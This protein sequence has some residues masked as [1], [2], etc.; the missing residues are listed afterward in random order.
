MSSR[1]SSPACGILSDG[2]PQPPRSFKRQQTLD[3][4]Y[5]ATKIR[6]AIRGKTKGE[7]WATFDMQQ[8][9]DI[10]QQARLNLKKYRNAHANM[11]TIEFYFPEKYDEDEEV[12]WLKRTFGEDLKPAVRG[13][14][15]AAAAYDDQVDDEEEMPKVKTEMEHEFE[16]PAAVKG[17]DAVT[18]GKEKI[19]VS[20][21]V[22]SAHDDPVVKV[23]CRGFVLGDGGAKVGSKKA[24]GMKKGGTA[25]MAKVGPQGVRKGRGIR[26]SWKWVGG[27]MV[28][29]PPFDAVN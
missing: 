19:A 11:R 15:A 5:Y 8:R 4:V 14:G 27:K 10:V 23:V 1:E 26:R 17:G 18:G 24:M 22:G 29:W 7:K 3:R 21:A 28:V 9:W 16:I 13:G 2:P 25:S 12:A 20:S 6:E